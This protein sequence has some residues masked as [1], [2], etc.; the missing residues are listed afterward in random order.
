M[1]DFVLHYLLS[2]AQTIII[3]WVAKN[4]FEYKT[5]SLIGCVFVYVIIPYGLVTA[6]SFRNVWI[7][8]ASSL[9]AIIVVYFVL[10]RASVVQKIVL[11]AIVFVANMLCESISVFFAAIIFGDRTETIIESSIY[12]WVYTSITLMLFFSIACLIKI[13]MSRRHNS[14]KSAFFSVGGLRML[15]LPIIT[16]ILGYYIM[17]SSQFMADNLALYFGLSLFFLLIIIDILLLFGTERDFRKYEHKTV[18]DAMELQ[19]EYHIKSIHQMQSALTEHS[20][21]AHDFKNHLMVLSGMAID[22]RRNPLNYLQIEE[23]VRQLIENIDEVDQTQFTHVDNSALRVIL[24]RA[25]TECEEAGIELQADIPYSSYDFMAFAD[26]CALFSNAFDNA[27]YACKQLAE[28][29]KIKRICAE[30]YIHQTSVIFKLRNSYT[31]PIVR[32]GAGFLS[33]KGGDYR[34]GIGT[35]NI[36][37]SVERY[38]GVVQISSVDGI[39]DL[40][41]D[42]PLPDR[43]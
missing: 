32:H 18:T 5:R 6:N 4:F 38:N 16:I 41:V 8:V 19:E 1:L 15:L 20:A 25:F 26:I 42:I 13:L 36:R 14:E 43:L 34:V 17:Y 24:Q 22:A 3:A 35:R 39:F 2:V 11:A 7:N 33:Q 29:M 23:Y 21:L 9:A 12:N 27:I 40:T 37:R 30:S 31:T 28:P 10:V